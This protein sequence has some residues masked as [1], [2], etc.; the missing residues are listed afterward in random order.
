MVKGLNRVDNRR[1]G[2]PGILHKR[3]NYQVYHKSTYLFESF[4]FVMHN[5]AQVIF[6]DQVGHQVTLH[7]KVMSG[8][9]LTLKYLLVSL[10]IFGTFIS[11][12]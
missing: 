8:V 2:K 1:V 3:F 12:L 6:P 7:S 4:Q 11:K 9:L 5:R 10:K